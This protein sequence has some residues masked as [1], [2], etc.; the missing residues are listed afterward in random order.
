MSPPSF[1]FQYASEARDKPSRVTEPA[2]TLGLSDRVLD[3]GIHIHAESAFFADKLAT[4][5]SLAAFRNLA[6]PK[7][8]KAL[9]QYLGAQLTEPKTALLAVVRKSGQCE[10]GNTQKR[11][12][13]CRST[14]YEP[15][16]A[17]RQPFVAVQDQVVTQVE[18]EELI[19]WLTYHHT[20]PSSEKEFGRRNYVW[21]TFTW[22]QDGQML[23]AVSKGGG[24]KRTVIIEDCIIEVVELVHTSNGH[25]GWDTTW[26][27]VNH[28]S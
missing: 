10:A 19:G 15:A 17:E 27:D 18:R 9:E 8:L 6:F 22:D 1:P 3:N 2:S 24:K 13:C 16:E 25:A 26:R 14:Y 12:A 11:Q 5:E 28:S 23:A 21:K 20:P 4:E 7:Q